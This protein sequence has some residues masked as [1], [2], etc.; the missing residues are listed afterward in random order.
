VVNLKLVQKSVPIKDPIESS[1]LNLFFLVLLTTLCFKL[2]M[3]LLSM[4]YI[5]YAFGKLGYTNV[6]SH[7]NSILILCFS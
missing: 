6:H 2:K 5:A 4:H 7:E 1:V 3:L